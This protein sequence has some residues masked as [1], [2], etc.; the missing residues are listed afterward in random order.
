M[1]VGQQPPS[2]R[3]PNIPASSTIRTLP[4]ASPAGRPPT[5]LSSTGAT[6]ARQAS[7]AARAEVL[8]APAFPDDHVHAG[9]R[10][11]DPEHHRQLL[12][13]Q[14]PAGKC[15]GNVVGSASPTPA[16]GPAAAAVRT[17]TSVANISPVV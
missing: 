5:G 4:R 2:G 13:R 7:A 3:V 1:D 15:D 8:P 14:L 12:V 6:P 9:A 11:R 10:A 17:A 16:N